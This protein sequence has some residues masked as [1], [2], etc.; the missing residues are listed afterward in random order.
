MMLALLP[1]GLVSCVKEDFEAGE[2]DLEN[3]LGV[4]FPSQSETSFELEPGDGTETLE[5]TVK[6]LKSEGAADVPYTFSVSPEPVN[7]VEIKASDIRFE[8]GQTE[9]SFTVSV[10]L[11]VTDMVGVEYTCSISVDD[12]EYALTYG[13]YSPSMDISFIV[14]KWNKLGTADAPYGTWRDDILSYGY[15]TNLGAENAEVTVY[16]RDDLRGYFRLEN[17]YSAEYLCALVD[18]GTG[19]PD[20][21]LEYVTEVQMIIDA[22]NPSAVVFPMQEIGV[23]LGLGMVSAASYSSEYFPIEDEENLF[24]TYDAATGLIEF[25][26][27]SILVNEPGYDSGW[28]AGNASGMTRLILPGFSVSDY[29]ISFDAGL[30][31]SGLLPVYYTLGADVTRAR[32]A[33][34]EGTLSEAAAQEKAE[35]I[36]DGTETAQVEEISAETSGS[37]DPGDPYLEISGLETGVYTLVSA[38][39]GAASENGAS[40]EYKDFSYVTFCYIAEGD[41]VPVVLDME[42]NVTDK[43]QAEGHTSENSLEMYVAGA[44]IEEAYMILERGDYTEME[45]S[46]LE[47]MF[48]E[49]IN[50]GLIEPVDEETLAAINSEGYLDVASGLVPGTEYSLLVYA[51]N[52]YR[53]DVK[54]ISATTAGEYDVL[55]D[56]FTAYDLIPVTAASELYGTYDYYGVDLSGKTGEREKIGTVTIGEGSDGLVSVKGLL[57]PAASE[58]GVDDVLPFAFDGEYGVLGSL[59]KAFDTEYLVDGKIPLHLGTGFYDMNNGVIS[60]LDSPDDQLLW[61]GKV[62]AAGNVLAL[63]DSGAYGDYPG[64]SGEPYSCSGIGLVGYDSEKYFL[65][66]KNLSGYIDVILVRSGSAGTESGGDTEPGTLSM[67]NCLVPAGID[68]AARDAAGVSFSVSAR[69]GTAPHRARTAATSVSVR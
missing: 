5:F 2:P 49:Q 52:G 9:T 16:E 35:G 38:N 56:S 30:S 54:V 53:W 24:G 6:R 12:P 3:C 50:Y 32:Y 43:Y 44:D 34:Y 29:S 55:A 7:G 61:G 11:N 59:F 40:D 33:V 4:Y 47:M 39:Y 14:V 65:S 18:D 10:P 23:N 48:Q 67:R 21:Y 31:V 60:W 57:G 64:A 63:V 46:D 28:Y 51:G 68:C 42:L 13:E 22:T 17:T 27:Q 19:S 26:A 36:A 45:A 8:D 62:D 69:K 58:A 66:V 20:D 15:M 25:P 1:A 41:D 37:S